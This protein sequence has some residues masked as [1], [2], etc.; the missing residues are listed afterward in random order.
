M[1]ASAKN[2][3]P[4]GEKEMTALTALGPAALAL[5]AFV[6]VISALVA[7]YSVEQAV[8]RAIGR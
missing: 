7:A 5:V 4:A 1:P 2:Q 3:P 6:G 8:R